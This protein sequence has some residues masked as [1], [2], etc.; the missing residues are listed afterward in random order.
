MSAIALAQSK[1]SFRSVGTIVIAL[2]ILTLIL[3]FM[4]AAIGAFH[5]PPLTLL[6]ILYEA[7][8][9]TGWIEPSATER[10]IVLGIRLPRILLG[11]LVGANLAL[12]GSVMQGLFRNPLADPG[13]IG[14]SPGAAVAAVAVIVLGAPA[15]FGSAAVPIAAFIGGLAATVFVF[16]IGTRSGVTT[17]TVMLLAGIGVNALAQSMTGYLV[18]RSNEFQLR[19]FTFWT[20]GSL[21]GARWD[22]LQVAGPILLIPL[23]LLPLLARGLNA[24]VLGER[25]ARYLGVEVQRL[26]IAAVI[27]TALGVG[28]ATSMA[29]I[30]G[31]VGIV[32]PHIIRLLGGADHRF[33]LPASIF[34]GASFLILADIVA[35][36]VVV[37]AEL[38]IGVVTAAVGAPFFLWLIVQRRVRV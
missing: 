33:L 38:P 9:G 30:L 29:G 36:T 13:L 26:K 25:E 34:T 21:A 4:S 24:V 35:R 7:V 28:V 15:I 3:M 2:G 23:M 31:F 18:F 10:G 1:S 8:G 16:S 27:L 17:V 11:A 32:V 22:V 19:D 5:V 12:G 37:P 14:I 6:S 20:L